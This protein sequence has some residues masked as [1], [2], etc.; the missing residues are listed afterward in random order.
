MPDLQ[1]A[2]S[3]K[4]SKSIDLFM[5]L[6]NFSLLPSKGLNMHFIHS[7]NSVWHHV[8]PVKGDDTTVHKMKVFTKVIK[9]K[10]RCL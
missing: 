4:K 10:L 6:Q 1:A 2:E 8:E 3:F 5:I 7:L 9:W